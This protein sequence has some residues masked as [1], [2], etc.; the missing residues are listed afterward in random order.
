MKLVK[1]KVVCLGVLTSALALSPNALAVDLYIDEFGSDGS[2]CLD[3]ANPCA[4]IEYAVTNYAAAGD[5][6]HLTGMLLTEDVN[7]AVD[8]DFVGAGVGTT[9]IY[10]VAA[11]RHFTVEGGATVSFKDV[12]LTGGDGQGNDGGSILVLDGALSTVNVEFV[13]NWGYQGGAVSC[14]L[15]CSELDFKRTDFVENGA[16]RGG[17]VFTKSDAKFQNCLFDTNQS[18]VT[19]GAGIHG[20]NADLTVRDSEFEGNTA[21][22]MGAGI[23]AE[24]NV[25]FD[26]TVRRSYF[27]DNVIA[28][29]GSGAGIAMLD[30]GSLLVTNST[31][32]TN[33]SALGGAIYTF[34]NGATAMARHLTLVGNVGGPAQHISA[35]GTFELWD[36]I[37][38][39]S[40]GTECIGVG[41]GNN[42]ADGASCGTVVNAV[43]GLL[44]LGYFGGRTRTFA[45]DPASTAVNAVAA[46]SLNQDQRWAP[47]GGICD[48][49][50]YELQ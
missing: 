13:D 4:T 30:P 12:T 38:T 36:S 1:S 18:T 42:V 3:P 5:V 25:P 44:G 41:G 22:T 21:V 11:A 35:G 40:A 28:P 20:F 43:T 10:G 32:D 47:R 34:G 17:G 50:A 31:F 27:G 37:V 26:V 23:Y 19:T 2:G 29:F 33:S 14:K 15:N 6:L 7:V 16:T 48:I 39:G 49:G 8:L 9:Q 45:L 46:C 24:G